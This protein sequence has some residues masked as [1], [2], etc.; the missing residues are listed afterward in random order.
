MVGNDFG[1]H[2]IDAS[3]PNQAE[4]LMVDDEKKPEKIE[5]LNRYLQDQPRTSCGWLSPRKPVPGQTIQTILV[6][7]ST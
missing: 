6:R 2:T 5:A 3:I 7:S 1:G 4:A